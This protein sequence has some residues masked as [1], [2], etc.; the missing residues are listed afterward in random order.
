MSAGVCAAQYVVLTGQYLRVLAKES[1]EPWLP[2]TT[3]SDT[4]E[5]GVKGTR[6]L[7]G[8]SKSGAD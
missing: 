4:G 5:P 2:D 7:S 8:R 3:E 1:K 6:R